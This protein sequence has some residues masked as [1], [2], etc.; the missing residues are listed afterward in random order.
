MIHVKEKDWKAIAAKY[1]AKKPRYWKFK[2]PSCGHVQSVESVII[3][4]Q[5]LT[6]KEVSEWIYF[7]CEGRTNPKHGCDWTLGG[8]LGIH[9]LEVVQQD[10]STISVFEFADEKAMT[11]LKKFDFEVKKF[12]DW[13]G[14]L[15]IVR[16]DMEVVDSHD[17]KEKTI[18]KKGSIVE[19]RYHHGVH[20]RTIE[21]TY[22]Y[23]NEGYFLEHCEL[24]GR[25]D[26]DVC[27][28]NRTKTKE[29]LKSK[30]Y[31]PLLKVKA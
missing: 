30:L 28:K 5:E 3:H 14:S 8:L 23:A 12:S 18:I 7:N 24:F 29:I 13:H 27:W 22:W 1:Y 17:K 16:K 19:F 4:N 6:E 2:C 31:E 11:E 15:W 25:I 20:F 10:G 9:K 26:K 21:D